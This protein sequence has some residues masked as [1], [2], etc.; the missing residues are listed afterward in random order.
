M[1]NES[2]VLYFLH[3][4]L[5]EHFIDTR[6]L[7]LPRCGATSNLTKRVLQIRNKRSPA[8]QVKKDAS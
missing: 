1:I 8:N 7:G 6:K 4:I 2:N 3:I 5:K